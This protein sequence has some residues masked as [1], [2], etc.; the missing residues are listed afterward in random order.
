[1]QSMRSQPALK[2]K[3]ATQV[4]EHIRAHYNRNEVWRLILEEYQYWMSILQK[5]DSNR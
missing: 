3:F 5:K 1:M 4:R 2:D